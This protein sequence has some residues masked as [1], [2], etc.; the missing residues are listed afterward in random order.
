MTIIVHKHRDVAIL[1]LIG[2]LIIGK[3]V[4]TFREQVRELL[5]TGTRNFA[6]NLSEVPY[7]DSSGIGSLV[8]AYTSI[9]VAGA[10][11]KFFAAPQKVTQILTSVRLNEVFDLFQDEASALSSF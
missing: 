9:E 6:V 3:P 10:K 5:N 11:I 2:T 1:D 4:Q 7:L 8:G